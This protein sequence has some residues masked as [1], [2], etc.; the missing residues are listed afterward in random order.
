MNNKLLLQG[1]AFVLLGTTSCALCVTRIKVR[2]ETLKTLVLYFDSTIYKRPQIE[3][4]LPQQTRSVRLEDYSD[5]DVTK[6]IT[7]EAW[8]TFGNSVTWSFTQYDLRDNMTLNFSKLGDGP[9]TLT[10][11]SPK[12]SRKMVAPVSR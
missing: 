5:K 11:I 2:N 9:L 10:V 8:G 1:I 4:I 6:N 3:K 12:G 7:I